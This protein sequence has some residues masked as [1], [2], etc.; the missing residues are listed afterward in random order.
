LRAHPP[1]SIPQQRYEI[2]PTDVWYVDRRGRNAEENVEDARRV[3]LRMALRW[4]DR[5]RDAHHVLADLESGKLEV[6][7]NPSPIRHHLIAYTALHVGDDATAAEH[8]RALL[9]REI[10]I[11]WEAEVEAALARLEGG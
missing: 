10:P 7:A 11:G 4:F 6:G 8:F 9:E 5:Y 2:G 3:V 1:P